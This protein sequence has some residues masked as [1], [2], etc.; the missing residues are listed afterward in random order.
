MNLGLFAA[1]PLLLAA[2]RA[3]DWVLTGLTRID[4][5]IA[6]HL[7][8]PANGI[9]LSLRPGEERWGWRLI[10]VSFRERCAWVADLS[11]TVRVEVAGAPATSPS[12]PST[13]PLPLVEPERQAVPAATGGESSTPTG[14]GFAGVT[15]SEDAAGEAL[16]DGAGTAAQLASTASQAADT[17][18][19]ELL[20][21]PEPRRRATPD[22]LFRARNGYGAWE[23]LLRARHQEEALAASSAP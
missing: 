21:R 1:L 17:E 11:R 13:S 6:A 23:A 3:D 19:S 8:A 14:N 15:A 16:A 2:A 10:D 22:E 18:R 5:Q 4:G 20:R 12:V 7:L 9:S